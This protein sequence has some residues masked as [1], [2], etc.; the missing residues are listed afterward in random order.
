[1]NG[2]IKWTKLQYFAVSDSTV[3]RFREGDFV[4]ERTCE[5]C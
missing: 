3:R 4:R 2:L 1:M 5:A